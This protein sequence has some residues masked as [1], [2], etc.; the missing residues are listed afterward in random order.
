MLDAF[1]MTQEDLAKKTGKS[2]PWIS[3]HLSMLRLEEF[4]TPVIISKPSCSISEYHHHTS[5]P[6]CKLSE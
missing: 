5:K 4:I 3:Y 2:Q 1:K 6:S